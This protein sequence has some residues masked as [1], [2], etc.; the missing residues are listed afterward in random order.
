MPQA[1]PT[2]PSAT[3]RCPAVVVVVD[4]MEAI[5]GTELHL[6]ALARGLT[7]RGFRV[8]LL[9]LGHHGLAARVRE[10]GVE[11]IPWPVRKVVAPSY[12]ADVLRLARWL[13]SG[14]CDLVQSVHTAADLLAP[15]AAWLAGRLRCVSSRRD[16]GIFR[17]RRHRA[18]ARLINP[19]VDAFVGPSRAV[20]EAAQRLEGI[21]ESRCVVIP[22]GVDL[23]R[24]RPGLAPAVRA[25]LGLGA[26]TPIF[27]NVAS[28]TPAKRPVLLVEALALL[29][30]GSWPD[31][32]LV[33]AGDGPLRSAVQRKARELG[34][35]ERVHLLGV[36]QAPEEVYATLDVLVLP[37]RSEGLPN[38]LLEGMACGLPVVASAV[39][40]ISEVVAHEENGLLLPEVTPARISEAVAAVLDAPGRAGQLA[41]AA[42]AHV[43]AHFSLDSMVDAHA[44]LYRSLL[45]LPDPGGDEASG[46]ASVGG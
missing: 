18:L 4:E 10:A 20:C 46:C 34:V 41:S 35:A 44:R 16:L 1:P 24:F 42:R 30:A 29:L 25:E 8:R 26:Q 15:A 3:Q 22:N 23:Q 39:G 33:L 5:G 13:R 28:L 6:M 21:P 2:A 37:S 38:T 43:A 32:H 45:G 7:R 40:G 17:E 9:V 14:G 12:P 36:R 27:G 19:L 31:V 11:L